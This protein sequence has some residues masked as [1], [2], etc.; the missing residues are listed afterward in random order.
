[1]S[2]QLRTNDIVSWNDILIM[3]TWVRLLMYHLKRKTAIYSVLPLVIL[4]I[5][6]YAL[7]LIN[8]VALCI[9]GQDINKG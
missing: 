9:I 1:M 5:L 2:K 4:L 6:I 3:Y 8:Y 7:E